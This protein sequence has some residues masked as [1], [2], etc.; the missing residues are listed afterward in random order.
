MSNIDINIYAEDPVEG[1]QVARL[2]TATL[3]THGFTDVTSIAQLNQVQETEIDVVASMRAMN[4][5]I[6]TSEVLIAVSPYKEEIETINSNGLPG[7]EEFPQVGDGDED[8][9]Q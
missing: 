5:S 2:L 7:E 6:F 9:D 4:P 1:D 8:D 3:N